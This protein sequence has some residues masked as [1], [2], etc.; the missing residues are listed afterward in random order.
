VAVKA[1]GAEMTIIG[2]SASAHHTVAFFSKHA[3]KPNPTQPHM[4]ELST[5]GG[6]PLFSPSLHTQPQAYHKV[7]VAKP[8]MPCA[9]ST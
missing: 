7:G 5:C 3:L 9:T 1:M 2:S 4:L 6:A 8:H